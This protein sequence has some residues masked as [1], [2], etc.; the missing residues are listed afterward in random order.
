[1]RLKQIKLAGF[2]SFVDA[3]TVPF[4][5]QMTAIVGPNGCGKSNVID[6]VRWVLG[7][8]SAKNLRGDA[9]TDVIFNGSTN[10]KPVSQASVELVFDNAEGRLQGNLASRNEI[11]VKRQV[12]KEAQS[13]YFLNGSKC[14]RRDI[15]DIFLGTGLGPR[16]YAI[17]EQGMISRLIESKPQELRIF[18][19]EAAGI[20]KYKERRRET[21]NRIKHTRDNLERL[22]DVREELGANLE[23]L[24]RQAAT[25]RRFKDLKGKERKYKAELYALKWHKYNEQLNLYDKERLEKEAELEAF[26]AQQRGGEL[27][28]LQFKEQHQTLSDQVQSV[29]QRVYQVGNQITR[30]EQQIVFTQ[31]KHANQREEKIQLQHTIDESDEHLA[32]EQEKLELTLEELEQLAPE[33]EIIEEQMQQASEQLLIA[34]QAYEDWQSDWERQQKIASQSQQSAQVVQTKIQAQNTHIERLK[35]RQLSLSQNLSELD[36]KTLEDELE[37]LEEQLEQ[38][39]EV[40]LQLQ[41][42]KDE[43]ASKLAEKE[44]QKHT[45]QA[46][47]DQLH[48]ER[49]TLQIKLD[50][51]LQWQRDYQN[52]SQLNTE[53]QNEVLSQQSIDQFGLLLSQLEVQAEWQSAVETL[54]S[55]HGQATVVNTLPNSMNTG[56]F[57]SPVQENNKRAGSVA[58]VISKGQ[59]PEWLNDV[60][61]I[62]ASETQSQKDMQQILT[63]GQ[64]QSALSKSGVW[65]GK[66]WQSGGSIDSS[67]EVNVLA[68][69]AEIESLQAES[70]NT[71]KAY[72]QAEQELDDAKSQLNAT[73]QQLAEKEAEWQQ[74]QQLSNQLSVQQQLLK[75]K[76]EQSQLQVQKLE[77]EIESLTEQLELEEETLWGLEQE[78]EFSQEQK[79]ELENQLQEL[80]QKKSELQAQVNNSKM[81]LESCKNQNHQVALKKQT[82]NSQYDALQQNIT[83]ANQHKSQLE[84][85]LQQLNESL[86]LDSDP[87]ET[88]KMELEEQLLVRVEAEEELAI[89]QNELADVAQS[90]KELEQGQSGIMAKLDGMRA[91]IETIKLDGEG[92]RIRAQNMLETLNDME[93]PLKPV[94][95]SMPVDANED[96]WTQELEKTTHAISRLGAINLAAIEEYD[97]QAERKGYLDTQYQDLVDA[98]D[99][100]ES[101]IRKIDRESRAK[102]KE[103]YDRVNNDLQMLFPKV[104]GGGSAYL[105]LTDDDMLETGVTIMARPPGK[106][107]STIHLLSGGEKALTALSLVFS[108]FRLNPAPF[109]MLDEVDAPLDDANVG[110][111][112][113]LVKEMSDTVQF[114]YISHNKVAMEMATH[115]TG[116]TMQEP[117]VSRLVAVDIQDAVKMAEA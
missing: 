60:A 87:T 37:Q 5:D 3:T 12:N 68:R 81:Q 22:E 86:Q 41:L 79:F 52:G 108:I 15:T 67:G 66:N 74:Q 28:M 11:S 35:Q 59:F 27:G 109:C 23:K 16:S 9:M 63:D 34:E 107:N 105:E 75:Q 65:Y 31:E 71:E 51:L 89:K 77:L 42:S 72:S 26:I 64:W 10:R 97:V 83:R 57:I 90:I 50:N 19:E 40:V 56:H 17:I 61:L 91:D 46:Q 29:Q 111:F 7:E 100:L 76:V 2:K 21:E 39:N 8:S 53:A 47:Y 70:E 33:L 54:L 103:T 44:Q 82:L 48:A 49:N 113:K 88:L 1:M 25:A 30:L 99:T 62:D 43:V 102:F 110:R 95:E 20:S 115:L 98:L 13:T 101:A 80:E 112:C 116:V 84:Q 104:F 85:K 4:P 93:Q 92:A 6:A 117:G 45:A 14:R 96:E 36:A 114:I 58:S 69:F 38:E 18:I 78:L 73:K 32:F 94:L 24:K 55:H 106:K